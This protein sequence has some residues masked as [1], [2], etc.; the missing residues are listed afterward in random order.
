MKISQLAKLS[1]MSAHTLRYYEKSGLITS[2]KRSG[3]NY[4]EY[5]ED[6]VATALFIKRC[7]SSGFSLSDTAK[8]IVIKDAKDAHTCSEAKV[9]AQEKIVEISRQ[10][11]Q[12]AALKLVLHELSDTCCGGNESAKFCAIITKLEN[13]TVSQPAAKQSLQSL[14]EGK[15]HAL[16][17]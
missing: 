13:D 12:L 2:I 5:S 11:E 8:L 14:N 10:I 6:D 16:N 9:I 1:G 15:D 3:N 7:K 17:H 4:R